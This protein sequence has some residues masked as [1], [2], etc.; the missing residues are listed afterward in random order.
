[1]KVQHQ[2]FESLEKTEDGGKRV[3][4]IEIGGGVATAQ[5]QIWPRQVL[6]S[7]GIIVSMEEN[8]DTKTSTMVPRSMC[9]TLRG[10]TSMRSM[11]WHDARHVQSKVLY[12]VVWLSTQKYFLQPYSGLH[13][14]PLLVKRTDCS[15]KLSATASCVVSLSWCT[16]AG[17]QLQQALA[18]AADDG[19]KKL[20]TF[21]VNQCQPWSKR[22]AARGNPLINVMICPDDGPAVAWRIVDP[23]GQIKDTAYVAQLHRDLRGEI[24]AAVPN[25]HF[26]GYV[27]DSTATNRAAMRILQ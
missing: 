8:D 14:C 24:E 7:A 21:V 16:I 20:N 22:T 18:F 5:V 2:L 23:S 17:K 10:R 9:P 4:S 3:R 13:L 25:G 12:P 27:M 15:C 26:L 11:G 1:M 6:A 19:Q